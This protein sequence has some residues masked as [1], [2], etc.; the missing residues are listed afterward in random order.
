MCVLRDDYAAFGIFTELV[1]HGSDG[2]SQNMGG[3]CAVSFGLPQRCQYQ[4]S[5]HFGD[6]QTNQILGGSQIR[7][8]IV[9][10]SRFLSSP[11]LL[12]SQT[13]TD[14]VEGNG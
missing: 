8:E 6:R 9:H 3:M 5:F 10:F 13:N 7:R 11:S 1:P 4:T 14:S 12:C 2:N